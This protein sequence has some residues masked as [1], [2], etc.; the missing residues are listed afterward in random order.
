ME[1]ATMTILSLNRSLAGMSELF[2]RIVL[3]AAY[4][5]SDETHAT[6]LKAQTWG[7][8]ALTDMLPNYVL[9]FEVDWDAEQAKLAVAQLFPDQIANYDHLTRSLQQIKRIA[10][11]FS[12]PDLRNRAKE[13]DLRRADRALNDFFLYF[14]VIRDS[15]LSERALSAPEPADSK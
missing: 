14:A 10:M 7:H 9:P 5:E 2:Y 12:A 8:R 11:E 15:G 3:M 13:D 6:G 1:P 4:R